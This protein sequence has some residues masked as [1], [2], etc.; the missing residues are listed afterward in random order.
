MKF[1]NTP[2]I[3]I[4]SMNTAYEQKVWPI[5]SYRILT[6]GFNSLPI[7]YNS[8]CF[9]TL[10]RLIPS[11]SLSSSMPPNPSYHRQCPASPVGRCTL[12]VKDI[13]NSFNIFLHR[14]CGKKGNISSDYDDI[15]IKYIRISAYNFGKAFTICFVFLYISKYRHINEE[16]LALIST[17]N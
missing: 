11:I 15:C 16:V 1:P 4:I 12:K 9:N 3:N 10:R 8:I 13:A 14:C 2:I 17:L 6:K 5:K 7:T